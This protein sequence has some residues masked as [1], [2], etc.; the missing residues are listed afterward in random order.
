MRLE[1]LEEVKKALE[2]INVTGMMITEVKGREEQKGI[3]LQFR[4]RE[5]HVD[6]LPKVKVE[7]V[8][9]NNVV[10]KVVNTIVNTARTRKLGDGKIFVIS[11]EKS[12]RVRTG[13]VGKIKYF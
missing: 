3:T 9:D 5:T 8:V 13:E 11:V 6:L 1:K 7:L 12:V 4:G 10:D 2:A